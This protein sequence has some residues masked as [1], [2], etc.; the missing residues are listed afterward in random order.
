MK[1][2]DPKSFVPFMGKP[3]STD[4]GGKP[5]LAWIAITDLRVDPKY[6]R[7]IL[8]GGARNV[9]NI[10]KHFNW[11][12]FGAVVVARL[13]DGSYA[14]VDGQHRTLAAALRH[15][16]HVPCIIIEADAG[17]QAA[18][19]AAINGAVTAI[20][21]L[22]IHH[23]EVMA[24]APE[25][26]SL[27]NTC[28]AA[29]VEIC[30]YPVPSSD[31]KKNQT[32]AIR[33]LQEAVRSYGH[34]HLKI[35]LMA[36]MASANV[37]GGIKATAIKAT[38]IALDACKAWK[39]DHERLIGAMARYDFSMEIAAAEV[40]AKQDRMPSHAALSLRLIDFLETSIPLAA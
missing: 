30:R 36:I 9:G 18:A 8:R 7:E 40:T 15:I 27:R 21:P 29:G 28:S 31:I 26:V 13:A 35:A 25:A 14:I 37:K 16:T 32:L 10:A 3:I 24:G 17:E 23:A 5:E 19:F 34:P 4:L 6:Q 38:C 11:S 12:L 33:A 2:V 39:V 22:A 1:H 20:S